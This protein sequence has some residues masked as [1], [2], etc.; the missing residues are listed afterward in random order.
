[1][2]KPVLP[3]R[4]KLELNEREG[5]VE[6]STTWKKVWRN[7][8]VR[9]W[10]TRLISNQRHFLVVPKNLQRNHSSPK[11]T[12]MMI[13]KSLHVPFAWIS[14]IHLWIS[15]RFQG[16]LINFVLIVLTSGRR[17]RTNAPAVSNVLIVL[18]VSK[19]CH[20]QLLQQLRGG[21]RER[22]VITRIILDR[23]RGGGLVKLLGVQH[24]LLLRRRHLHPESIHA[25]LKIEINNTCLRG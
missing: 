5:V 22:E 9:L 6:M 15:P 1:M 8:S 19:N 20:R 2:R 23:I 11:R 16:A 25:Q 18:T 17:L 12:L 3:K 10:Q 4:Q 14:L 7:N 21:E 24:Q 13:W